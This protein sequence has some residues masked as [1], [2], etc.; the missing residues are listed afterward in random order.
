MAGALIVAVIAAAVAVT[1][2]LYQA[3]IADAGK[4]R[5]ADVSS[6]RAQQ[7]VS[8]SAQQ[9]VDMFRYLTTGS[10]AYLSSAQAFDR[11]FDQVAGAVS[12][13]SP[14]GAQALAAARAAQDHFDSAFLEDRRLVT[15]SL[16]RKLTAIGQLDLA[17]DAITRSLNTLVGLETDRAAGSAAAASSAA[18]QALAIG[19][20]A[21]VLAVLTGLGFAL[22]MIGLLRRAHQRELELT[23]ALGRL[24][25]ALGRLGDRDELLARLRSAAAVLGEVAAEL[26]MAAR[27]AAAVTSEQSAAVAQTSATIQQ[28]ATTAGSIA[29][30]VR[31]VSQAAD[32]AGDTMRDMQEKVEAIS[33]RALSLGERT[34]K[35][36]EILELINDISGQTNLLAL[37]AAIDAARAG[38]AGRG[39]A[40]VAAEVRKLAERSMRST[41]SISVIITGVQD[42]TNA[43]IM[44]TE[45]GIRQARE[46]GELM[47]S[48]T[49]MLEE[50]ILATQQQKSAADQVDAAT[51]Q[52]REAAEQLAAEQAQWAATSERLEK[53]VDEIENALRE[54]SGELIHEHLHT[55]ESGR[56]S[57][58]RAD[59]KRRGNREP[60]RSDGRPGCAPAD[61]RRAE[62]A[63]PDPAR[64]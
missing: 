29:D 28:L 41:D 10:P 63:W 55:P 11:Q 3:A 47:A 34:Q 35:I 58:R 12:T 49:T 20:V 44:A 1:I 22:F 48:T 7:L 42:E 9:L 17:G 21:A 33:D 39:F 56:R 27:N 54:G 60:R 61:T 62:P 32:R 38:E 6:Q 51:Q 53:L 30:T 25:E 31:A 4:A 16:A 36:G 59:R 43:T 57:V 40:V 19:I 15:A 13:G 14:A 46:V 50:S 23:E 24:T 52:I 5:A 45:Q 2:G 26:R 8:I 18:G 37:N 64:Y